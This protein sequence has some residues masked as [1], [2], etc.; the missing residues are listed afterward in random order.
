MTYTIHRQRGH[1]KQSSFP[2]RMLLKENEAAEM[3]D[4]PSNWVVVPN[5]SSKYGVR[6]QC[7]TQSLQ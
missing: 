3:L 5:Y 4:F 1:S 7:S 6:W 2:I